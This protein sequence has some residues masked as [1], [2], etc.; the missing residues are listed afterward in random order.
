MAAASGI[1]PAD[2]VIEVLYQTVPRR[3]RVDQPMPEVLALAAVE[4]VD[5]DA[6]LFNPGVIAEI[7]DALTLAVGQLEH[8]IVGN[9]AEIATEQLAGVDL[10]ETLRIMSS[11]I[12]LAF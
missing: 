3:D 4:I 8:M 10:V 7:E 5:R 2:R 9:A 11:A 6:L 1:C 12:G